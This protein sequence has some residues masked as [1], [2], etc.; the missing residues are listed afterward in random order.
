MS[1]FG[2]PLREED[3]ERDPWAQF[4][5][6]YEQAERAAVRAPVVIRG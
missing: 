5:R 3:V 2:R 6:W 1:E 4:T